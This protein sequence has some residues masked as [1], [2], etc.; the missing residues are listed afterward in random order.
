MARIP[1]KEGAAAAM[2]AAGIGVW[3]WN[4]ED[5]L[6]E[7]SP[8]AAALLGSKETSLT[9]VQFFDLVHVDDRTFVGRS[10]NERL[11]SGQ[12]HD[13]DF[14]IAEG[15]KWRRMCGKRGE[16]AADGVVLDIGE[17]RA[18]QLS[19]ARLAAIMASSDDAIIGKTID[20]I[21]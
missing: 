20:G 7:L 3:R 4:F 15:A 14:R 13:V 8:L 11:A 5:G 21:V 16:G 12:L 10:A 1:V 19:N 9:Q 18:E 2:E 6:I 17:R